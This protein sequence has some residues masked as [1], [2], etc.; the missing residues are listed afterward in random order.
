MTGGNGSNLELN[1]TFQPIAGGNDTYDSLVSINSIKV[2]GTGYEAGDILNVSGLSPGYS[3]VVK[4]AKVGVNL[5]NA[6]GEIFN[7]RMGIGQALYKEG[8][9]S[10]I[11]TGLA[12]TSPLY[13]TTGFLEVVH[14]PGGYAGSGCATY[15]DGTSSSGTVD[16]IVPDINNCIIRHVGGNSA[17]CGKF[18]IR[19]IIDGTEII[20][21]ARD[22]W[23]IQDTSLSQTIDPKSSIQVVIDQGTEANAE[24]D[25]FTKFEVISATTQQRALLITC[26]FEPTV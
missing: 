18:R 13:G 16:V 20:N 5:E 25:V 23:H 3:S 19:V 1:M 4:V 10:T 2:A 26:R 7:S 22:N 17:G 15:T 12:E 21:S 24:S 11:N 9:E 14:A 8:E 6:A